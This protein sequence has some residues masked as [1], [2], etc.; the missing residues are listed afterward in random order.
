MLLSYKSLKYSKNNL[1]S[2]INPLNSLVLTILSGISG[3]SGIFFK[4]IMLDA[5]I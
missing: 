5:D 2:N 1:K 4:V 3:I